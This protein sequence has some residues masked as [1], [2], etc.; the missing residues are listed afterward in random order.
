DPLD[1]SYRIAEAKKVA[2]QFL[3][4]YAGTDENAE[5][6][7]SIVWFGSSAGV[8]KNWVNVAGGAGKNSYDS[9]YSYL[10]GLKAPHSG[11]RG[12]TNLEAGLRAAEAQLDA[13]SNIVEQKNVVLLTDGK[14]TYRVGKNGGTAGDGQSGSEANNNAAAAVA[15]DIKE[16]ASLYTVCIAAEDD[17]CYS[18][19]DVHVCENCD[20]TRDHHIKDEV[21]RYCGE[22][23]SD[24]NPVEYGRYTVYYCENSYRTYE[25]E[26]SY[27]CDSTMTTKY[28]DKVISGDVTVGYFLSNDIASSAATAFNASSSADLE[29][30]LKAIASKIE[31]TGM[32]GQGT[33]VTDPMGQFIVLGDVS[34]LSADGVTANG[35]TIEWELDPEKAV[36]AVDGNTTTYT[37]SITYPITLNTAA[38]GFEEVDAD[39]NTKYYPTNGY[40]YLGVPQADGTTKEIAFLVPGVNGTIP[41]IPWTVEYYLQDES[42]IGKV[43]TYTMDKD[44]AQDSVKA[45]TSVAAPNGYETEYSSENYTFAGGNVRLEVTPN[46][47]NVMKLYYN[48][49]TSDVTVNHYYKTD[50]IEADG[51]EV[52]G[53]YPAVPQKSSVYPWKI[54]T[55]FTATPDPEYDQAM[56]ELDSQISDGLLHLVQVDSEANVIDLYYDRLVDNRVITSA[57]VLH[58]YTTYGYE[59]NADGKYELAELGSVTESAEKAAAI[60]ATTLFDVSEDPLEG[61]TDFTLNPEL[62]DYAA[63]LQSDGTL[64]FKVVDNAANNIRTLHFEKVVDTRTAVDVVVNHYYTK[65]ATEIMNGEVITTVNP[66]GKLGYT[67]TYPAYLGE[68]FEAAEINVYNGDAYNSDAG[69]AGKL[70]ID[71]L[72]GDARIDL[73]YDLSETPEVTEIIVN[74]IWRT[75]EHVTVEVTETIPVEVADPETGEVSI[76]YETVVTG[77]KVEIQETIDHEIDGSEDP[78]DLYIGQKYTAPK[79]VWGEGYYFNEKDSNDTGIGGSDAVLNLYYDKILS[80]DERSDAEIDVQHNYVTWL[81]TIVDGAVDTVRVPDGTATESYPAD[82]GAMKAGDSFTAEA[83]P[84]YNGNDYTQITPDAELGPVILQPG[85]NDTIVINYERNFSDLIAVDYIVNYEYR[86]YTMELDANGEAVYGEPAVEEVSG[87]VQSGYAGLQVTLDPG[88]REGFAPLATNPA[89]TQT[90]AAEGNVW[91]F[92]HEQYIPLERGQVAVNHHYTTEIIAL[93]GTTSSVT[94]DVM[95]TPEAMYQGEAYEANA[96][97][98]GFTLTG[99]QVDAA[100]QALADSITVTVGANTVIDFYYYKTIDN[101]VKAPYTITHQYYLYDWDGSLLSGPDPNAQPDITGEGFVTT[102]ITAAPAPSDYTMISAEYNGADLGELTGTAYTVNLIEGN[103]DIVFVY[104]KTLAR[105]MVD[106]IVIHKYYQDE[107][108]LLNGAEPLAEYQLP[109]VEVYEGETYTADIREEAGYTFLNADPE[110]RTLVVAEDGENIILLNYVRAEASYEVVHIYNHNGAEEGKTSEVYGGYVGDLVKADDIARVPAYNG[111]TYIFVS[112][113][114]DIVL[115]ANAV[116]VITLVYNRSTWTPTDPDPVDPPVNPDPVDPPADPVEPEDPPV[117]IPDE[118]VPLADLPDEE[119]PLADIP[120][121]DVP[122]ADVPKTGDNSPLFMVLALLSGLG[123]AILGITGRKRRETA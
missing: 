61:Y 101:S 32:T 64:S 83:A 67:N 71:A 46:G 66:N 98:N 22:A 11:D 77:T 81:E 30:A 105:D 43:P 37:Y 65:I 41:M 84:S 96:V 68:K 28:R 14:P 8:D 59:L 57:E 110:D 50:V 78:I 15:D 69:N 51:T 88:N 99:L 18:G 112:I 118:D 76:S 122:L 73:Y 119:V 4:S 29:A 42:S 19:A 49:I 24:H 25:S 90:L 20:Q 113:T 115:D 17:V 36:K 123:L 70:V 13:R 89:V 102:P 120:E 100:D 35:N 103:N 1:N 97:P 107:E 86:T 33:T 87:I 60:R 31:E 52:P 63:L 104:E 2:K 38:Q 9:I 93:D 117:D 23:R 26:T 48:I 21:C 56:Y 58:V 111:N 109:D 94:D 72:T 85:T 121:E 54:Y 55:N 80:S 53:E 7:L 74:H 34:A 116:K 39:G 44:D 79:E 6:Y 16:S 45:W 62:G 10:D 114:D 82:G 12:G 106:L 75:Y 27:Y 5:Q 92:V 108:A 95:G 40:T 91:T 3:A 47:D